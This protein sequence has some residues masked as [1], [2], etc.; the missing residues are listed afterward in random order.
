MRKLLTGMLFG[1]VLCLAAAFVQPGAALPVSAAERTVAIDSCLVSGANVEVS[2]SGA[3]PASDDGRYY[4]FSDEVYEDGAQGVVIAT[5]RAASRTG[6]AFPLNLNSAGNQISRKFMVMVK[7][8]GR[9]VQVSNEHYITNPEAAATAAALRMDH[10]I[11]GILPTNID[12]TLADLGIDQIAYNIYLGD[13]VGESDNPGWGT[14]HYGYDGQVWDF[15][16]AAVARLDELVKLITAQGIQMNVTILNTPG[17]S[18]ADL[19]HP[20]S[21]DKSSIDCPCFAF[22]TAEAGGAKHLKAIAA[23]LGQRYN[24]ASG[25]GQIDNW[26]IGNEVNARSECFY[27]SNTDLDFNASAYHKAF[28]IFYNGIRSMNASAH[29]YIPLDQEWGRKSNPGCFLSKEY[30]DVF[31]SYMLREGNVDWG[32]A[33]HPYNAPLNDPYAWKGQAIY[34]QKSVATP[35]ITM[36]NISVLTDYMQQPSMLA[37]NGQVRSISISEIGYTSAFGEELQAASIVYAYMMAANNPHIDGFLLYR[38]TDNSKEMLTNIIQG[39]C[40]PDGSHKMAYDY[41][42]YIDTEQAAVYRDK[43]SRI[44]GTDVGALVSGQ[45][46]LT[47]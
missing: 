14:I 30:L 26:L 22:N 35:Y 31:N 28:R 42:K 29:V 8:G 32:L 37:P 25:N 11:K 23:F 20:L 40:R 10:G 46:L 7:Q 47:R 15:N 44:I 34:V 12:G 19:I 1:A 2:V 43:A 36:Q 38:E 21:R 24:G 6:F 9:Y 45:V 5:A 3:V 17:A 39:L 4:L 41:Y 18:G 16:G 13:I 27:M 33:F